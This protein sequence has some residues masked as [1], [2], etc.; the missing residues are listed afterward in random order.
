MIRERE[1]ER[2]PK[3][4]SS[5]EAEQR[6]KYRTMKRRQKERK[7]DMRRSTYKTHKHN[8]GFFTTSVYRCARR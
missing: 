8:T 4:V 2:E 1:R 3:Q 6:Y 7:I 5:K